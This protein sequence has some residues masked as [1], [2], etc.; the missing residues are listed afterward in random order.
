MASISGQS[1]TNID[2]VD[3]F[4]TTQG[5]GA[6]ATPTPTLTAIDTYGTGEATITNM[7]AYTSVV[8]QCEVYVG[9]TL[10]V[11]N[12][13]TTTNGGTITWADTS[14]L[15]GTR[16]VQVR[17]Q[18]FG[19]FIQSAVGSTTYTKNPTTFRYFRCRSV[20]ST[21]SNSNAHMGIRDWR[22]ENASA[23]IYPSNMTADNLPTPFVASAGAYYST[24]YP[25]KAFDSNTSTF[26]WTL[27]SSFATNYVDIDMGASV[28]LVTGK[29][30]FYSGS[31]ASYFTISGST[32]GTNFT[33]LND[34]I[35]VNKTNAYQ[36]LL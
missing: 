24:Y 23:T 29:I 13:N 15:T 9:S 5:G 3:G 19:D 25:Y 36:T 4:F 12:A 21:G 11:S 30:M 35:A 22:Y 17:A 2:N 33:I 7:A 8:F 34:T 18:E 16:T 10:I 28:T 27:T 26:A 31:S 6:T 1:T 20:T 14:S 32:D